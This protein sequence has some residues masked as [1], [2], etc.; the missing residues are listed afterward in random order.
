V[1][2]REL[3]RIRR[4]DSTTTI[5]SLYVPDLFV[6]AAMI[7][8]AGYQKDFGSQSDD[9]QAANARVGNRKDN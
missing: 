3:H 1:R 7:F 8:M 2:F 5:L 4:N 6:A 9:P